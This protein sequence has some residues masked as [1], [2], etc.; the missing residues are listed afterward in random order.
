MTKLRRSTL[1]WRNSES[2]SS[3]RLSS[4]E[5]RWVVRSVATL[6]VVGSLL[7]FFL[8]FTSLSY[9]PNISLN[10]EQEEDCTTYN[11]VDQNQRFIIFKEYDG[12]GAGNTMEGLLAVHI[13]GLEFNRIV[14]VHPSFTGFHLAFESY[15]PKI[16]SACSRLFKCDMGVQNPDV[17]DF[18]RM[19]NFHPPLDECQLQENMASFEN[20][21]IWIEGNTYPRWPRLPENLLF[22]EYYRPTQALL[23]VLPWTTP[24]RRV[25]HLRAPDS[26]KDI[27][28]GLDD[29]TLEVLGET[30]PTD[31]Y[32]VTNQVLW[33]DWFAER[34]GWSHPP[35]QGIVHSAQAISWGNRNGD[36]I[37]RRVLD[38]ESKRIGSL[39]L[40]ADW[41]TILRASSVIHTHSDFS[42]SAVHWMNIVDSSV[43][44][45]SSM[46]LNDG[47]LRFK[48]EHFRLGIPAA[49]LSQRRKDSALPETQRLE[50]CKTV[51]E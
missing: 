45:K 41:Y 17:Y 8:V 38:N 48:P 34:Y 39:Q 13:F 9:V 14:C 12:Q 24:P 36:N 27:R 32:L 25:V 23:D 51:K 11:E 15:H 21:V 7:W 30:L 33:Y 26:T 40:W 47:K 44:M 31:T 1:M 16:K 28:D 4:K 18:I 37:P 50:H 49:L 43:L 3:I 6:L 19:L 35:W 5:R 10:M 42:S 20:R 46:D 2:S 22:T 29:A